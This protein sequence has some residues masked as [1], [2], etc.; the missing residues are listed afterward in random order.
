M[1]AGLLAAFT[2]RF[3]GLVLLVLP[4]QLALAAIDEFVV[5]ARYLHREGVGPAWGRV[6][7]PLRDRLGTVVLYQVVKDGLGTAAAVVVFG[8]TLCTCCVA[9]PPHVGSVILLPLAVFLRPYE[10]F[11]LRQLGPNL[12]LITPAP[13]AADLR[14]RASG[15][16]PPP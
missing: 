1:G 2:V 11:F 9:A 3:A 15:F 10:L 6:R 5:P 16:A 13:A 14:D 4:M 8:A 7:G 12:T